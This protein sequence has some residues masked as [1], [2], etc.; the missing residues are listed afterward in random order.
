MS[1]EQ[2]NALLSNL[3][4]E[5][6]VLAKLRVELEGRKGKLC[7]SCKGFGHLA[8]NCRKRKKGEKR[9][10][11]PQNKFEVLRSRVMQ[12]SVEER[13]VRSMRTA[14]VRCF[15]C[16]E[17]GHKCRTCSKKEKRVACPREGKVHQGERK[18]VRRVEGREAAHVARPQKAQQEKRPAHPVRGKA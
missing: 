4:R 15:K 9:V 8:Q 18:E 17:E 16:G 2:Y 1:Q 12:C 3:L 13:V 6:H 14:V 10:E 11:M 7:R 5:K